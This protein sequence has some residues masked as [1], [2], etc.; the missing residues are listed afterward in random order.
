MAYVSDSTN[1]HRQK[2][3]FVVFPFYF[4]KCTQVHASPFFS[5]NLNKV[6]SKAVLLLGDLNEVNVAKV[7]FQTW[8]LKFHFV[9]IMSEVKLHQF[10]FSKP[11]FFR[12]HSK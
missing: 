6:M 11:D 10:L 1:F 5:S 12:A 3:F 2:S 4:I 7:L 9:Q 8:I